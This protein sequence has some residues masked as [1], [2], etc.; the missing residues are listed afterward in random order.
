MY[1]KGYN[2]MAKVCHTWDHYTK[3]SLGIRYEAIKSDLGTIFRIS[4]MYQGLR[5][6]VIHVSGMDTLWIE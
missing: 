3:Y 5:D 2:N 6:I 4:M 1:G